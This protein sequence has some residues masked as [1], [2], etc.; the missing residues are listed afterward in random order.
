MIRKSGRAAARASECS[1][2]RTRRGAR[3]DGRPGRRRRVTCAGW[4]AA[5]GGR[6]VCGTGGRGPGLRPAPGR[7]P[8]QP[9][10]AGSGRES[11]E[12]DRGRMRL[13]S[14][15][16]LMI[17]RL[18][19]ATWIPLSKYRVIAVGRW[20]G[21][22]SGTAAPGRNRSLGPRR[23]SLPGLLLF[24]HGTIARRPASPCGPMDLSDRR[25]PCGAHR[26]T[27]AG[28][29]PLDRW[30]EANGA[31]S[32]RQGEAPRVPGRRLTGSGGSPKRPAR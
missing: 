15:D 6:R 32:R 14:G 10:C 12:V 9:G 28:A 3:R 16:P 5:K 25:E 13:E 19:A 17:A 23:M 2:A 11:R 31:T 22:R 1:T 27:P 18:V 8:P 26:E 21:D 20:R 7:R 29:F 24:G 30:S 4:A